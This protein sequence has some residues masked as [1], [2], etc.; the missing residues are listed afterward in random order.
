M[1]LI[2]FKGSALLII[3]FLVF[4][5]SYHFFKKERITY[6]LWLVI[7]GGFILR[8]W[9]ASDSFLHE[10]D[11][12][13]HA[14][15]AKHLAENPLLPL[16]YKTPLL[17]YDYREWSANHVWLHKQPFPLWLMAGSIRLFGINEWALRLPSLILSTIAIYLTFKIVSNLQNEQTGL[18]AAALQAI[19]GFVIEL[20][21]GRQATDHIDN[22]FLF[23]MELSVFYI[24]LFEQ[25][26][27]LRFLLFIGLS[28]GLAILT[29]WLPA[30][31]VLIIFT[32]LLFDRK[33]K[34]LIF[35]NVG[36]ILI[37]AGAVALPWQIYIFSRFP[38]EANWESHYNFLHITSV[39]GNQ[40][41][42]WWFY[43]ENARIQWNEAIYVVV[44]WF[45]MGLFRKSFD[46]RYWAL[47]LW[48]V[49]PYSFFSAIQTKM[50]GYVLFTAPAVF[51][52]IAMFWWEFKA[53]PLKY[54]F[55][56]N[57]LLFVI[58][59]LAVRYSV[60]RVKPFE[61]D[62]KSVAEAN[63]MKGLNSM[64]KNKKVVIFNMDKNIEGM[65]YTDFTIYAS[66]PNTDE[67]ESLNQRGYK[68]FMI[69]NNL[70]PAI[71]LN[72]KDVSYL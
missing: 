26:R 23:L 31:I 18:L 30:L 37:T 57:T 48:I 29:K 20:A 46:R 36:V 19:N 72:R 22:V 60:E 69:K 2:Y 63:F 1:A 27:R 39:L 55:F 56:N 49:V 41:G 28:M 67:I 42:G 65:F 8:V 61:D 45:L 17:P 11:E 66:L 21:S 71:L 9:C 44:I 4:G 14:L 68:V 12:R 35:K 16:L 15:V 32:V 70:L 33:Q 64:I 50:V 54:R 24:I 13:Y 6:S 59:A 43:L 34:G 10:W 47:G 51:A 58:L 40:S 52:L 38:L 5:F 3:S 62:S 25:S 53:R 7:M